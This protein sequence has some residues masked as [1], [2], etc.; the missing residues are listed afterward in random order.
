MSNDNTK[1]ESYVPSFAD[2]QANIDALKA[3][4]NTPEPEEIY[5]DDDGVP[6]APKPVAKAAPVLDDVLMDDA[7]T[8]FDDDAEPGL[9]RPNFEAAKE[10]TDQELVDEATKTEESVKAEQKQTVVELKDYIEKLEN[11]KVMHKIDG[12]LVELDLKEALKEITNTYSGHKA[13]DKRFTEL[14][15]EKKMVYNQIQAQEQVIQNFNKFREAGDIVGGYTYIGSLTGTPGYMIKEQLIAALAPEIERR[16]ALSD[17]QLQSEFLRQENEY[18]SQQREAELRSQKEAQAIKERDLQVTKLRET[19][20]IDEKTW[21]EAFKQLDAELAPGMPIT[22]EMVVD[23]AKSK[24]NESKTLDLVNSVSSKF[25]LPSEEIKALEL[26]IK[27]YPTFSQQDIEE[28]VQESLEI[29]SKQKT[30]KKL[31]SKLQ[32]NNSVSQAQPEMTPEQAAEEF[33][34]QAGLKMPWE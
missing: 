21:D 11:T 32:N 1:D 26:I 25:N 14:D 27:Q 28:I 20:G 24:L 8:Q 16:Y 2:V 29:S 3:E 22:P 34:R 4:T 19:Q 23:K 18:L 17:E 13:V 31:A 7:P 5:I 6:E 30:E 33:R 10:Q 12:E 9:E 15:K